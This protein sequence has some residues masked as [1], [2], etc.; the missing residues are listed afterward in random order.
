[1]STR[2]LFDLESHPGPAADIFQ[3]I[4]LDVCKDLTKLRKKSAFRPWLTSVALHRC[5]RWKDRQARELIGQAELLSDAA[6]A[7]VSDAVEEPSW[8]GEL[9]TPTSWLGMGCDASSL[10]AVN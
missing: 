1:M 9:E 10:D 8:V 5:Y 2:S 6:N 4:W 3:Q 7:A